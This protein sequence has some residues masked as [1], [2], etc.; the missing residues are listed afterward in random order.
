MKLCF[1]SDTHSLHEQVQVPFSDVLIHSGD[2]SGQGTEK[3]IRDFVKW[4]SGK[5][6]KHKIFVPG[7]HEILVEKNL[8]IY[9]KIFEDNGIYFLCNDLIKIEGVSFF[10]SPYTPIFG[11]WAFMRNE[12][13]RCDLWNK[14]PSADI[15]ICHGPPYSILDKNVGCKYFL[16]YCLYTTPSLVAFGHIHESYGTFKDHAMGTLFINSSQTNEKYKIV[17]KPILVDFNYKN[18]KFKLLDYK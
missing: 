13:E 17:N 18:K 4:F 8:S 2:I 12:E 16:K 14:A 6:N 9:K 7:N 1:I 5:E 11:K 10:G 15:V 3:E